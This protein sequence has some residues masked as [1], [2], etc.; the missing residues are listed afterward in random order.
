MD[1]GIWIYKD[2]LPAIEPEFRLSIGE[3]STRIQKLE[4][5]YGSIY[6]KHEE[7]NP[8]GSFKDRSMA[9]WMSK[10][11]SFSKRNFVI[12]SSGNAAMSAVGFA[13]LMR[14]ELTV[15]VSVNIPE[16]KWDK[17]TKFSGNT[18]NIKLIRSVKPKS[19]AIRY[20]NE[21]GAINLRGSSDDLAIEGFCTIGYEL[22]EQNP[23]IDAIFI[24]CSSGTAAIGIYNGIKQLS[25]RPVKL[26]IVQTTKICPIASVFDKQYSA[27][28][29]SLANAVSDKVAKRKSELIDIVNLTGGSGWVISDKELVDAKAELVRHGKNLDGY[30]AYVGFAGYK[31]AIAN[32][33]QYEYPVIIISGL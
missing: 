22:I 12:S 31:K 16:Y 25:E 1:S 7:E 24:C 17:L 20:A 4:L 10:Y 11:N 15:F 5:D 27:T 26:N 2:L 8:S 3:G 28:D 18:T 6:L 23:N 13:K 21:T 33:I 9:Y 32:G 30:N 29:R 14:A 19:D